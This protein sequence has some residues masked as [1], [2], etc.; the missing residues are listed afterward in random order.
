M[1]TESRGATIVNAAGKATVPLVAS[2]PEPEGGG[3][4][5]PFKLYYGVGY[6]TIGEMKSLGEKLAVTA[7]P[8]E[9]QLGDAN[10]PVPSSGFYTLY[11]V[12]QS[13]V[14]YIT[15]VYVQK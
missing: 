14:E 8:G 6:R 12:T 7:R 2:M 9:L 5:E 4:P 13:R 11:M 1:K 3:S 15:Y 10:L